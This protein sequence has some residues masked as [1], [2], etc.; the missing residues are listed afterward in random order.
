MTRR[1]LGSGRRTSS[2][3]AVMVR[4]EDTRVTTR[5]LRW[6]AGPSISSPGNRRGA[7][8]LYSSTMTRKALR[9]L[10]LLSLGRCCKPAVVPLPE[11]PLKGGVES[12]TTRRRVLSLDQPRS[13][14]VDLVRECFYTTP[15]I[16][17]PSSKVFSKTCIRRL[18]LPQLST[19]P[20]QE[21]A[22]S[23]R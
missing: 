3:F 20:G 16:R 17:S 10:T 1:L 12:S 6:R 9:R 8:C 14:G 5:R 2:I 19:R 22:E 15:T 18:S 11:L 7:T 13:S 4:A 23:R 21:S